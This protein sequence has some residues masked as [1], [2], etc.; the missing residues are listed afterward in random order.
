VATHRL[1]ERHDFTDYARAVR[2]RRMIRESL[3]RA[4]AR[5]AWQ[6]SSLMVVRIVHLGIIA[7]AI[8]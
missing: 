3:L 6:S 1:C 8:G 2:Q 5:T 4:L 7:I